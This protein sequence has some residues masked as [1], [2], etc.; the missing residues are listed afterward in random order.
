MTGG[1]VDQEGCFEGAGVLILGYLA[2]EGRV[3]CA[4]TYTWSARTKH[5]PKRENEVGGERTEA[6]LAALAL[7]PQLVNVQREQHE[8]ATNS[9]VVSARGYWDRSLHPGQERGLVAHGPEEHRK[10]DDLQTK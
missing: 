6:P 3:A 7:H 5:R 9:R 10:V 2:V 8:A 1:K 4:H